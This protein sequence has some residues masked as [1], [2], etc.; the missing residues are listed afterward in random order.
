MEI[1]VLGAGE[2]GRGV[3]SCTAQAGLE[4]VVYDRSPE[5][6]ER[7]RELLAQGLRFQ[8]LLGGPKV[9]DPEAVLSLLRWTTDPVDLSGCG[10][11]VENV[12]EPWECKQEAYAVLETHNQ[13]AV[14]AA[15]TSAH[16]ISELGSLL[17]KPERLVGIHF[18]NPVPLKPMVELI[19]SKQSSQEAR[20]QTRAF[21]ERLGKTAIE[22]GD[23]RGF[24]SNRVL[25]LMVNE[26]IR[27]LEEGVAT[28][29]TID[30]VFEG[31]AGHK[32]GPLAT[33]DL[34]GLDTILHTLEVLRKQPDSERFQP[35]QL[36][37]EMVARG[38]LGR[39][40]GRGFF[41]YG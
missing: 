10:Y 4:T 41:N 11:L 31:C 38:E 40:S 8:G 27:T 39:K 18:M 16:P 23:S 33:A 5:Q 19:F 1:G 22:V 34:I 37:Q 9:D 2:I 32:M 20:Q 7:G 30:R 35:A 13:S 26:A 12:S 29:A 36:L 28:A 17:A 14:I 21:L 25:M 24:V 3:A 15:N 6:L